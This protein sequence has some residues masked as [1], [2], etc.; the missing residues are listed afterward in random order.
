MTTEGMSPLAKPF[1]FL[2]SPATLTP[3][4]QI[5]VTLPVIT[6]DNAAIA[7]VARD[8]KL[9]KDAGDSSRGSTSNIFCKMCCAETPHSPPRREAFILLFGGGKTDLHPDSA[10]WL[11]PI[12]TWCLIIGVIIGTGGIGIILIHFLQPFLRIIVVALAYVAWAILFPAIT[13][14][15]TK[16][17]HSNRNPRALWVAI[18]V[19]ST[20]ILVIAGN[21]A[22]TRFSAS[23]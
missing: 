3:A 2:D 1:A 5:P 7:V 17:N 4:T 18:A 9:K 19:W 16:C 13:W 6:V 23:W 21:Y 8:G 15:C 11:T 12:I 20:I 10:G 14:H 22:S